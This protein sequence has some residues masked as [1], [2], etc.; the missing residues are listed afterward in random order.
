MAFPFKPLAKEPTNV[1]LRYLSALF[2]PLLHLLR[3]HVD[4]DGEVRRQELTD[5]NVS[6]LVIVLHAYNAP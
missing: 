6:D 4:I 2:Q 5:A 1:P 3:R